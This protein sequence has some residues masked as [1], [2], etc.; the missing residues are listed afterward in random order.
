MIIILIGYMASGKSRIGNDLATKLN[1]R[2]VDLDDHIEAKEKLKIPEIFSEKGEIYFR[3]IETE[4]LKQLIGESE[5]MVL[6]LGGGTPC[7]GGNMDM[8]SVQKDVLTV[9]LK[10]GPE[11]IV[12]RLQSET[13]G[14]PLVAHLKDR[15]ELLDFVRKHLFERAT[16]YSQAGLTITT[17]DK[18]PASVIEEIILNLFED[19]A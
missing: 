5:S 2:F 12:D 4:Y 3:R 16:Y 8:I 9:Y 11:T 15:E 18:S 17:D 10:A 14:R 1:F 19:G 13:T 7:Y 6:A